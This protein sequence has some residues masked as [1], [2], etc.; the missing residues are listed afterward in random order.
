MS[1]DIFFRK[2]AIQLHCIVLRFGG[3]QYSLR[4]KRY[5]ALRA[6]SLQVS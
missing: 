1:R 6:F 5:T 2:F 3:R 4:C